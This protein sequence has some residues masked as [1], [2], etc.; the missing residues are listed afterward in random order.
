MGKLLGMPDVSG[1]DATRKL[2]E[3]LPIIQEVNKQFRNPVSCG[4]V[5]H[6]VKVKFS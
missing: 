1:D 2:E 5:N 4:G 6:Q 3:T